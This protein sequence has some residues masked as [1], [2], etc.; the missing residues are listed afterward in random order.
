M[1]GQWRRQQAGAE[2]QPASARRPGEQTLGPARPHESG[3]RGRRRKRAFPSPASAAPPCTAILPSVAA[4]LRAAVPSQTPVPPPP[5][6]Q[7]RLSS[8]HPQR[9]TA[10]CPPSR[11]Q[12]WLLV[13]ALRRRVRQR[14]LTSLPA[15]GSIK[16]PLLH[17]Q[18]SFGAPA[19]RAGARTCPGTEAQPRANLC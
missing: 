18:I 11:G 1:Q 9:P 14:R 5:Q 8:G 10:C 12:T 3:R 7:P 17:P 19:E 15:T 16:L 2:S 13:H 6:S 4:R